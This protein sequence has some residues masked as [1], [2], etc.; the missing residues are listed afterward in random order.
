MILILTS[1][2]GDMSHPRFIDWLEYYN[3]DYIIISGESIASGELNIS[4]NSYG[5]L[6]INNERIDHKISVVLNRR[7]F[8]H[9]EL[10]NIDTDKKLNQDLRRNI[11]NEIY[12][13]KGYL[14]K[15]NKALWIPNEFASEINKIDV[16]IKAKAVGL[17]V[18][19]FCITNEK[20]ALNLFYNKHKNIIT[21]AIGNF[22][23][24]WNS[25]GILINPIYT[26]IVDGNLI[27]SLSD[28]FTLS[29]FQKLI[30]KKKEYRSLF[31]KDKLFT[32]EILTQEN[33][34]SIV[35]SRAKK[36]EDSR[37]R[38]VKSKLPKEVENLT[39]KLMSI[40]NLNIG[41][42]D[43]IQDY[44]DNFYFLEV[45]PVGQISGYSLRG[46]LNFEKIVVEEMIKIDNERKKA[47]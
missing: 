12:E 27:N 47:K 25:E 13:I 41:C 20:K 19:N 14:E 22:R 33:D 9:S 5:E 30:R 24:V 7:F 26:K 10:S 15:L 36:D 46:N 31:F 6:F 42:I 3:A 29:L 11:I 21:K 43:F 4:I 18:P 28:K 40:L 2:A 45:N 8:T 16:L 35:D 37:I 17:N 44:N 32:V 38:I 34:Y 39:I 23:P 1:R